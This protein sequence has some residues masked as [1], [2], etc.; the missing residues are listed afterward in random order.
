M[1]VSAAMHALLLGLLLGVTS[2]TA[3][4]LEWV[5]VNECDLPYFGVTEEILQLV[6][7]MSY[8]TFRCG[9]P[10]VSIRVCMHAMHLLRLSC[11]L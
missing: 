9:T 10:I 2:T 8:N 3:L 7:G 11:H 1:P 4:P 6:G 5:Q